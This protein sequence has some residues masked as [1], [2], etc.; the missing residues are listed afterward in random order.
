MGFFVWKRWPRVILP[1]AMP[2]I[3]PGTTA[4]PCSMTIQCT[5]RT[6]SAAPAPQRMRRA[7]GSLS[8]AAWTMPGRSFA[9]GEPARVVR[10]NRNSP[11]SSAMRVRWSTATPQD[12]AKASLAARVG[13]PAASKAALTG[14]PRRSTRC[15][16]WRS[17]SLR[18]RTAR[19]RG[20]KEVSMAA[21]CDRPPASRPATTPS[22]K[23]SPRAARL[24]GGISSAPIST[25]KSWRFISLRTDQ[26]EALRFSARVIRAGN[27]TGQRTYTQD[28]PLPLGDADGLARI[29][30]V[31][32]VRGL[33]GLLVGG[34]RQRDLEQ[35]LAV[36]LALVEL[37]EQRSR[38]RVLEVEPATARLRSGGRRRRR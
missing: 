17:R 27:A 7:I 1:A 37:G 28:E 12:S 34:Q 35:R 26:R 18:T 15:S 3:S 29:E 30:Q 23:A 36:L 22:R 24:F 19:R 13:W 16:G 10:Q 2:R 25:R 6:D 20:V 31:E 38:V 14:G 4:S 21:P 8:S 9:A 11:L 32:D 5:G 33:E